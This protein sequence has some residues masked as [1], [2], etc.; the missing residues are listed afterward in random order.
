[1]SLVIVCGG[2]AIMV[3]VVTI[4]IVII[5]VLFQASLV[6]VVCVGA[7]GDQGKVMVLLFF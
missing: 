2:T 5:L 3:F 1:M 6:M 7:E 4:M